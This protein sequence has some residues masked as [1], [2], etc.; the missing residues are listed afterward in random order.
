[1]SVLTAPAPPAPGTEPL[2]RRPSPP[3]RVLRWVRE[4]LVQ[5][6]AALALL[7]LFVPVA[8]VVLFSFN[9]PAGRFN[10]TWQGFSTRASSKPRAT[11]T[12]RP[13]PGSA[14]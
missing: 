6:Y 4:H 11:C 12:P 5:M 1:M 14:G 3:A 7:Y 2:R 9:D 10:F 13:S 8:V